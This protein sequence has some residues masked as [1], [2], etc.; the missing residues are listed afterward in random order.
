MRKIIILPFA[1]Q[2]I[3][4]STEYYQGMDVDLDKQF[5][6]VINQ[7]FQLI[8]DNPLSFPSV[9]PNIRKFVV[10]NFPFNIFYIAAKDIIYILAVF[11]MKRDPKK[12]KERIN[13]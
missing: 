4:E 6:K 2:D 5:L 11:H 1:E 10:K 9:N 7:A 12:W 13:Y 3:R 8:S